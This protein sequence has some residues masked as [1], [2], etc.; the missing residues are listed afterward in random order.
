MATIGTPERRSPTADFGLE[1]RFRPD[2]PDPA[3]VFR[4]MLSLI[5]AFEFLD[6]QLVRSIDVKIEPVLLLE[7]IATGSIRTWFRSALQATD[8]SAL[9]E[10]DWKKVVGN[11]LYRAKYFLIN[12]LDDTTEISD[13]RQITDIE[14][15]LFE[16]AEGT[17]V[18]RIP[19]YVP[20]PTPALLEAVRLINDGLAPLD[21]TRDRARLLTP[22]GD[23]NFNLQ[24]NFVPEKV[25]ELLIKDSIVN[26]S[27]LILK[28]RKPDFLGESR[29]E[30][31]WEDHYMEAGIADKEW[32]GQFQERAF[33]IRPGDALKVEIESTVNYGYDGEVISK[34]HTILE[35]IDVVRYT[36]PS[37]RHLLRPGEQEGR[38]PTV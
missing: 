10:G 36:P 5:G 30:F 19:S 29:W 15:G 12:K 18:R 11:Y 8:D 4:C 14:R 34:S 25:A 38:S 28:L 23:A 37:Q 35:V 3:R 17:N 32:L 2:S 21:K 1:I 16:M 26:R 31:R 13:R 7:D 20:I 33:D 22:E 27:I 24:L 6:R 9:K